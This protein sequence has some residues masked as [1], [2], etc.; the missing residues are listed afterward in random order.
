MQIKDVPYAS[1]SPDV[2]LTALESKGYEPDG[3]LLA[4]NSYENR[5]YQVG[6]EAGP[7]L[8]VKFYRPGRWSREA[9]LEEHQFAMEL[10]EQEIPIVLPVKDAN[11]ETLL[12]SHGFYFAVFPRQGGRWPELDNEDNL[13]WLGRLL[14]RVHMVGASGQFQ[15]RPRL[16]VQRMGQESYE[17]LLEHGFI[18]RDLTLSYRAIAEQVLDHIRLVFDQ[19][20]RYLRIYGDCH[21][22]NIL[23]SDQ[24]PFFVDLDDCVTGPA[25]QDLWMLLSGDREDMERQMQCVLRGYS[26]FRDFDFAELQL[27]ESLR[28]LRIMHYA[29]WIARRWSDP[30][31]PHVFSWFNTQRYWEEHILS[32]QEQLALLQE[33]ALEIPW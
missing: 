12:E 6:M 1:L 21:P 5:V 29:A 7:P 11:G 20:F 23:W 14:G 27:I 10:A 28:T 16:T 30:A 15:H 32:L 9:I 31:F 8:V 33:P 19:G 25:I 3:S 2:I 26:L 18:P 24:G 17:F 13:E 4:L 22:G